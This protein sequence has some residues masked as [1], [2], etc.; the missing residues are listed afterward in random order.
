[1]GAAR[2]AERSISRYSVSQTDLSESFTTYAGMVGKGRDYTVVI[3]KRPVA[4]LTA[5]EPES[6]TRE[7]SWQQAQRELRSLIESVQ[8]GQ[9][10]LKLTALAQSPIYLVPII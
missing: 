1:M 10:R 3:R 6:I 7:L 2:P 4:L 8:G 9:V 5:S